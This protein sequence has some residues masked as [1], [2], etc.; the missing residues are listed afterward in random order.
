MNDILVEVDAGVEGTEDEDE[1]LG[2]FPRH[3]AE[4]FPSLYAQSLL[5]L[6]SN[7]T[8][9]SSSSDESTNSNEKK[10]NQ[11]YRIVYN[12]IGH[13]A[14][15]MA[16]IVEQCRLLQ[17]DGCGMAKS[18]DTSANCRPPRLR[19][20]RCSLGVALHQYQDASSEGSIGL[21]FTAAEINTKSTTYY[22]TR[23]QRSANLLAPFLISPMGRQ[24]V[25]P[26]T[27]RP[28]TLAAVA[29]AVV[30]AEIRATNATVNESGGRK[31]GGG[32]AHA[33][34]FSARRVRREALAKANSLLRCGGGSPNGCSTLGLYSSMGT[35]SSYTATFA[36]AG[37][38]GAPYSDS[39]M[40]ALLTALEG[41][42]PSP[43]GGMF[44]G[45]GGYSANNNVGFT[46][47]SSGN[48]NG[49]GNNTNENG[50]FMNITQSASNL[51]TPFVAAALAT[52]A[53]AASGNDLELAQKAATYVSRHHPALTVRRGLV[54]MGD[55]D[56]K[57][58][59]LCAAGSCF[60]LEELQHAFPNT[61]AADAS[62]TAE[63]VATVSDAATPSSSD[64][65]AR[66]LLRSRE[67]CT[68]PNHMGYASAKALGIQKLKEAGEGRV[69]VTGIIVELASYRIF[70]T[71]FAQ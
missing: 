67:C 29:A 50:N 32:A 57:D 10:K 5:V 40:A 47:I 37:L 27:M 41:D 38:A 69:R 34:G 8:A 70:S 62:A 52:T 49:S 2:S 36:A 9:S 31:R 48:E 16:A 4:H 17:M 61:V 26:Q 63:E 44:G 51:A 14:D 53:T 54:P 21:D 33:S 25:N 65:F 42:E 39:A 71:S 64:A 55:N 66:Q 18:G 30:T 28:L 7:D 59:N 3:L 15:A 46:S 43:A 56:A 6:V 11:Q 13:V 12:T 22:S 35:S 20:L 58:R 60:V 23:Q 68:V 24:F 19:V 1:E 45:A